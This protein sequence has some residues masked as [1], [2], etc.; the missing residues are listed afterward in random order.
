MIWIH[1]G[2][3]WKKL[4][5]FLFHRLVTLMLTA[6]NNKKDKKIRKKEGKKERKRGNQIHKK[7]GASNPGT[8]ESCGKWTENVKA[9][10]RDSR[11]S[12]HHQSE[13]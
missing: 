8:L 4:G 1:S 10:W 6:S 11:E 12:G 13:S 3:F 2:Q 7:N 9:S 5:N